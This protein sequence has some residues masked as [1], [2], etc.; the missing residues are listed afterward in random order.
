MIPSFEAEDERV[1]R[2]S[3][4]DA[5]NLIGELPLQPLAS[6]I[7]TD[8]DDRAVTERKHAD[9]ALQPIELACVRHP[10]VLVRNP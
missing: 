2:A 4:L 1:H 5:F 10:V 3:G 7:A 6:V 8:R 9:E